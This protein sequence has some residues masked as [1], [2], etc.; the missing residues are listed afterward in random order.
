L[1]GIPKVFEIVNLM[2]D[3]G[4]PEAAIPE[5]SDGGH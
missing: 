2:I 3:G 5:F 1:E 4:S